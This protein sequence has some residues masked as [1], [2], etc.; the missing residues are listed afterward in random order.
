MLKDSEK[1]KEELGKIS[2]VLAKVAP[3]LTIISYVYEGIILPD[4]KRALPSI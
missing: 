2:E 3:G 1:L 4:K